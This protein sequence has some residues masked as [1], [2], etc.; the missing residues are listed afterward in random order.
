LPITPPTFKQCASSQ[1]KYVGDPC[2]HEHGNRNGRMDFGNNRGNDRGR[3]RSKKD[4]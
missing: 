3:G 1:E 2:R 4:D